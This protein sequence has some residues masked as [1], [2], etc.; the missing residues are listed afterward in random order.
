MFGRLAPGVT[1]AQAQTEFAAVAQRTAV[2]H[3]DTGLPLRPVVTPY[4]Q[5]IEDP[6]ILWALRAG[7]LF[8]GALT[9]VVAI[10]LAILVYARTVTR[11]G[12]IAVRTA[13]GASRRRIL[14]QLFMEALVL[15]VAGAAAGLGLARYAL[16]VIQALNDANGTLPYWIN[17]DLSLAAYLFAFGLAVMAA[18][19]MGVLPGPEGDPRRRQRPPA[20]TARPQ[21]HTVGCDLDDADRGAGGCRRRGAA[22]RG[23]RRVAR[24]SNGTGRCRL[25]G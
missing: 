14:A 12:E 20:R 9:V 10:N 13:L 4:T 11:L 22:A 5:V 6:A 7:Q 25:P 17:F 1:L 8:M 19:I 3:P 15:T 18:L 21:R 16:G 23:V 24:P 2:P